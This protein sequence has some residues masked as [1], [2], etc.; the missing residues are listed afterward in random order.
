MMKKILIILLKIF[1]AIVIAFALFIATVYFVNVF[2]NKSEAGKIKPYGQSVA[3]DGKNMNVLIQGK[4]EE[5]VVL[6]PGYGTPAPALDF[7][8]LID[9]LSPFYKVVVIE[10]FGYGLSDITEKERTTENMV[11]E[12]HEALQ[13]LNITHYTLMG[14]SISGIYGLDYV[15][16][17]PNEVNAFVGIDSSVPTQGGNDDPFPTDVY[18]L[19]KK[20]GFY[21]LLMKLAPDQLIAPAVDDETREQIRM[22]SLKNTFNPNNLS[23]GEN[24]GPNFKAAEGLTFPK[25]LPVI[26]FL[27]ANDTETEGWIPMHEEQVKNS[28]HGKVMTFEGGHYLHH[29][30][31]K[32]IAENFKKFMNEVK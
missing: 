30:R 27:Q 9:E 19:L 18:K 32:E 24:F 23:E 5:T 1:G 25:D 20:S 11:S 12:I 3:V 16:K 8:P 26:F 7:K 14:H 31:S 2:S 28:V 29:T 17:Y 22:L 13:Q 21:R 6:L 4:G 15:N 10:P